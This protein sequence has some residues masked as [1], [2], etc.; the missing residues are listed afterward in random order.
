MT[1]PSRTPLPTR[2][3]ALDYPEGTD[4]AWNP[5]FPEFA[6]AANSISLIMP[7]A[8]PYF[9]RVGRKALPLIEDEDLADRTSQ[10]LRQETSHHKQHRRFNDLVAAKYPGI[11]RIETWMAKAYGHVERKRSLEFNMAF[12]AGSETMAY[13]IA[14]W[15]EK[16]LDDL[17]ASSNSAVATMFIWHLAEEVEHKDAG[18]NAWE[19]MDGSRLRYTAAMTLSFIFLV[20]FVWLATFTQLWHDKRLRYP[21]TWFR[22]ARWA[23]SLAF[24]MLPMMASSATPGHHPNDFAD[25]IYLPTWLRQFDPETGTL[26]PLVA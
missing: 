22:L 12:I 9:V 11:P 1:E 10:F 3:I 7:Y 17:F 15:S 21:V 23:I 25:P 4:P 5:R 16:H 19:A 20:W 2:K 8:E 6:A 18:F 13:A 24:T 26:P 14:R